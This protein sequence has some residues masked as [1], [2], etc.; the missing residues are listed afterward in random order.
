M[1]RLD[2]PAWWVRLWAR[3]EPLPKGPFLNLRGRGVTCKGVGAALRVG[4]RPPSP[5]P[6]PRR[7]AGWRGV[8]PA[9]PL[10]TPWEPPLGSCE[11]GGGPSGRPP[12]SYRPALCGIQERWRARSTMQYSSRSVAARHQPDVSNT[13]TGRKAAPPPAAGA[14]GQ[15]VLCRRSAPR[16][17][18]KFSFALRTRP[19]GVLRPAMTSGWWVGPSYHS[20][21]DTKPRK[22]HTDHCH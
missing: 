16:S 1:R 8:A 18:A 19:V 13:P 6:S 14:V 22:P 3:F 10:G 20:T 15:S 12:S 17:R 5:L 11:G 21:L 4:L 9:P 2:F 7:G